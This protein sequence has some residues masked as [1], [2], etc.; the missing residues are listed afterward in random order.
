MKTTISYLLIFDYCLSIQPLFAQDK[1]KKALQVQ[2]FACNSG[3]VVGCNLFTTLPQSQL[4]CSNT[5]ITYPGPVGNSCVDGAAN[6]NWG[7]ISGR[8]NQTWF[9]IRINTSG[10]IKFNGTIYYLTQI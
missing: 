8:N 6:T 7:C 2:N 5:S 9:Y 3:T 10:S 4:V 1:P